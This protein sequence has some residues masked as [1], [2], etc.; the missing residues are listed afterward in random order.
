MSEK[1]S[2]MRVDAGVVEAKP[3]I[4]DQSAPSQA[5]GTVAWLKSRQVG[6]FAEKVTDFDLA[7]HPSRAP[8]VCRRLLAMGYCKYSEKSEL[9]FKKCIFPPFLQL[10]VLPS[11]AG[12]DRPVRTHLQGNRGE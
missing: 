2:L 5:V 7:K 9:K 8:M 10:P 1:S 4:V 11:A 6:K 3:A 12:P